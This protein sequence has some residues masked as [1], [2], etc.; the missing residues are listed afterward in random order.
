MTNA[1]KEWGNSREQNQ[2]NRLTVSPPDAKE[3]FGI[4]C[5]A[6]GSPVSANVNVR[7]EIVIDRLASTPACSI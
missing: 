3:M 5:L 4:S 1:P 7:Y 2:F 6:K